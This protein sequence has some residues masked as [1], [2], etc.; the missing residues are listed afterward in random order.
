[1]HKVDGVVVAS[2]SAT[3]VV[4]A[5]STSAHSWQ[6]GGG[7]FVHTLLHQEGTKAGSAAMASAHSC[8]SYLFI[9]F[10]VLSCGLCLLVFVFTPKC[11]IDQF[12]MIEF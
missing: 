2:S 4:C 6:V 9:L 5:C 10:M 3:D 1:M 12:Y 11:V 8:L 7:Y